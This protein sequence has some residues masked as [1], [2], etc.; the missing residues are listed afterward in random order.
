MEQ[1][2]NGVRPRRTPIKRNPA[3]TVGGDPQTSLPLQGEADSAEASSAEATTTTTKWVSKRR[4][5]KGGLGSTITDHGYP[6]DEVRSA[7]QKAIRRGQE[8]DAAW[9]AYQIIKHGWVKYLWR[10]L[11]LIAS[12]DVGMGDPMVAV[13]I[14]SLANNAREG[15]DDFKKDMFVGLCE[16]Q[17]ICVLCRAKKTWESTHLMCVTSR[18]WGDIQDGLA[19]L[20]IPPDEALDS[21]TVEG[22]RRKVSPLQWYAEGDALQPRGEKHHLNLDENGKSPDVY[23]DKVQRDK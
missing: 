17:A 1:N 7:L 12:E 19:D 9:W 18:R 22:R 11:R 21:H 5:G 2:G 23:T 15:T 3:T 4:D 10:T 14:D 16:M 20:P 13:I 6:M 8:E